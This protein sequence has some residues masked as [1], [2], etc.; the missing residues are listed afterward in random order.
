MQH[1][2]DETFGLYLGDAL[3]ENE[4]TALLAHVD[5]CGSCARTLND[6]I[7]VDAALSSRR[8]T[9]VPPLF[10]RRIRARAAI[11]AAEPLARWRLGVAAAVLLAIG[12]LGGVAAVRTFAP[13]AAIV[14][15]AAGPKFAFVFAEDPDALA[16]ASAAER[17][18]QYGEFI[19]WMY[20]LGD[21]RVRLGGS[22][23]DDSRG[24]IVG[25]GAQTAMAADLVLSG[26][27]VVRAS[28]YDEAERLA[29]DCPIVARGGQVIVRQL[30]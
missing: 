10:A 28:G 14:R 7:D 8:G 20:A 23:L 21:D 13:P 12:G 27:L 16:N 11:S 30:R 29:R 4:R 5:T 9:A 19:R 22:Q 1:P 25:A 2:T 15:D 26:F 24:R 3:S 6:L 18:R 17:Q